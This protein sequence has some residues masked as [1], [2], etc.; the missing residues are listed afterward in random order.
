[1]CRRCVVDKNK[2]AQALREYTVARLL[3]QL[4]RRATLTRGDA[5]RTTY[6][7]QA[8]SYWLLLLH[9]YWME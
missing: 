5:S 4:S 1:M 9:S 8:D 3:Q 7:S 6:S 2:P